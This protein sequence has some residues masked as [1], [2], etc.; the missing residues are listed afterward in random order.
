MDQQLQHLKVKSA[1]DLASMSSQGNAPEL[2]NLVSSAPVHFNNVVDQ[3]GSMVIKDN[4]A[5]TSNARKPQEGQPHKLNQNQYAKNFTPKN[6]INYLQQKQ[7]FQ[8]HLSGPQPASF[9]LQVEEPPNILGG[10]YRSHAEEQLYRNH[11]GPQPASFRSKGVEQGYGHH[12]LSDPQPQPQTASYRPQGDRRFANSF[13]HNSKPQFPVNFSE[14]SISFSKENSQSMSVY[15]GNAFNSGLPAPNDE[16]DFRRSQIIYPGDPY[17]IGHRN[18][19]SEVVGKTPYSHHQSI[20]HPRDSRLAMDSHH[21]NEMDHNL[22]GNNHSNNNFLQENDDVGISFFSS[23]TKGQS[24]VG[25]PYSG[26][27]PSVIYSQHNFS[28][29]LSPVAGT[30][31]LNLQQPLFEKSSSVYIVQP[32]PTSLLSSPLSPIQSP[33][34][35]HHVPIFNGFHSVLPS[36]MGMGYHI[37]GNSS[38]DVHY[39]PMQSQQSPLDF[40]GHGFVQADYAS[41]VMHSAQQKTSHVL[42]VHPQRYAGQNSMGGPVAASF[43]QTSSHA[44]AP[45]SALEIIPPAKEHSEVSPTTAE[46][47]ID[48]SAESYPVDGE[49]SNYDSGAG[50][51]STSAGGNANDSSNPKSVTKP[52]SKVVANRLKNMTSN[53]SQSAPFVN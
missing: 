15:P 43:Q 40:F 33:L 23:S 34:I 53:V 49:E 17:A 47:N 22:M 20:L 27:Q 14:P 2:S 28:Q 19:G 12:M 39:S 10:N 32:V 6:S 1:N 35:A 3:L 50:D 38:A 48:G 45:K 42:A 11:M 37:F 25:L 46:R 13:N 18:E 4:S 52:R 30:R 5:K 16:Q 21:R 26:Q 9:R 51:F 41:K 29:I 36:P 7:A 24:M 31:P 44:T 8:P